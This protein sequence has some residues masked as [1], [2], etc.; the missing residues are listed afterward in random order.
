MQINKKLSTI[1]ITALL[2]LSI[3]AAAVP[4]FAVVNADLGVWLTSAVASPVG[5]VTS[6]TVGQ[7]IQVIGATPNA[8]ANPGNTVN[9]YWDVISAASLLGTVPTGATGAFAI[10]VTI[11][12]AVNGAVHNIVVSDGVAPN[13]FQPITVNAK[14]TTSVTPSTGAIVRALPGE[15]INLAGSGFAANTLTTITFNG[16]A[17]TPITATTNV[18][19]SFTATMVIPADTTLSATAYTV[20]ATQAGP[21]TATASVT[22]NYYVT[23]TP[24]SGPTGIT[25]TI[26]G[27]IPASTAYTVTIAGT[28]VATT[29]IASGTSSTTGTF[30]NPYTI[31]TLLAAQPYTIIVTWAV[32]NTV[33]VGFTVLAPPTATLSASSGV[34]GQVI[35]VTGTNFVAGSNVTISFGTTVVN[36]TATDSRFGPTSATGALTAA[37]FSVP[38]L[39]PGTY[40]VTLVDQ[41]GASATVTGGF[42]INAAPV[43][44][45]ITAASFAQGDTISFSIVTTEASYTAGPIVTIR[46]PAGTTWFV[47]IAWPLTGTTTKTVLFQDQLI[48]G[49]HIVLPSNAPLGSWNWTVTYTPQSTGVPTKATD[50]FTV[51]A[52]GIGGVVSAINGLNATLV[53][54]QNGIATLTTNVGTVTTS[55]NSLSA[56]ISSISGGVVTI[57]TNLGTVTTKLSSIDAVIGYIAND[58]ATLSTSLGPITT[59]LS[60]IN[61]TLTSIQGDVATIKTDVGTLQGTVTSIKDGV[62]T[63]QTGVGTLQTNVGNLQTDVTSTKDNSSSLSPLLYVAIVLALIAAIAAVFCVIIVR[64]K[65]AS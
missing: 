3:V 5:T 14:L 7:R 12:A 64:Q 21:I 56:S 35:T 51:S 44:T 6:A 62:A 46:D 49:Q 55:V 39:T 23:A 40:V 61:P 45:I 48:S 2:I 63:I 58:T 19:G 29:Q 26:A 42:T 30:S 37:A 33:S 11:P 54:I 43:T 18:N 20:T 13:L 27:R 22:V 34:V 59:Q 17:F 9:V 57:Q 52:G 31:P 28:G 38:S 32:T 50:L 8:T 47:S 41:Y 16:G 65:I 15:P 4:A 60:A 24:F 25:V 1:A 10:N 36:S 53:S